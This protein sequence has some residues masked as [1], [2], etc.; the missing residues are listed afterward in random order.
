MIGIKTLRAMTGVACGPSPLL[1][2]TRES[3]QCF[4]QDCDFV[5]TI[6]D[7]INQLEHSMAIEYPQYMKHTLKELHN[8]LAAQNLPSATIKHIKH[9]VSQDKATLRR[10]KI[11]AKQQAKQWEV[12]HPPLNAEI[13]RV[14][15]SLAYKG[16][17]SPQRRAAFTE[18][19]DVLL[20][21]RS[22][23][24]NLAEQ[25]H[26]DG[27]PHTPGQLVKLLA[28]EGKHIPYDG[29]HWSDWVSPKDKRSVMGAFSKLSDER[30]VRAKMKEPFERR[31]TPVLWLR[32]KD[33][34]LS[35]LES[36]KRVAVTKHYVMKDAKTYA[37]AEQIKQAIIRLNQVPEY[38][39]LPRDWRK[40]L[41]EGGF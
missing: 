1:Y 9:I 7:I 31:T 32:T 10:E 30:K 24:K 5:D 21:T 29:I 3:G 37:H 6:W 15:S 26:E 39:P 8:I 36:L 12:L 2:L 34:L 16:N 18:Y 17:T 11:R 23:L 4:D 28:E 13:L 22:R 38:R 33:E 35:H 20:R 19:L 40:L 14:K 25:L 41:V 27:E